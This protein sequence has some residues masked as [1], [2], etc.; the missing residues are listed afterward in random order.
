M[1]GKI[2]EVECLVVHDAPEVVGRTGPACVQV[3]IGIVIAECAT[4]NIAL[5][6][7]GGFVHLKG[8]RV[9]RHAE[10]GPTVRWAI[11]SIWSFTNLEDFEL[12]RCTGHHQRLG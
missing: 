2:W 11:E 12:L 10:R 3:T 4:E 7:D 8:W 9:D 5:L 6:D 1:I